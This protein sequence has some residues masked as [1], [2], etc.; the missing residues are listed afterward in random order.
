MR[1]LQ[2]HKVGHTGKSWGRKSRERERPSDEVRDHLMF[3][4][5]RWTE[6]YTRR[7]K[8]I[9][10]RWHDVVLI[11]WSREPVYFELWH[12]E[13]DHNYNLWVIT[14]DV[15]GKTFSIISEHAA[16][17]WTGQDDVVLQPL[18]WA[19]LVFS[20]IY[21]VSCDLIPGQI[22]HTKEDEMHN[23]THILIG[24]HYLHLNV[25]KKYRIFLITIR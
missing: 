6:Y 14:L 21:Q 5:C 18:P 9:F 1:S 25:T 4:S 20:V 24:K 11:L 13:L 16:R 17:T 19:E 7:S 15:R 2:H 8:I 12:L 22:V 3:T 23:L 10:G